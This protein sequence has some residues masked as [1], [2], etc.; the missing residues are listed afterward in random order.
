MIE[1]EMQLA[2]GKWVPVAA[3]DVAFPEATLSSASGYGGP[4]DQLYMLI[5]AGTCGARVVVSGSAASR[6]HVPGAHVDTFC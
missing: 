2:N 5:N 1:I 3:C 6:P 4:Q